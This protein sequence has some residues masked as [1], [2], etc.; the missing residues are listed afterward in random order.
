VNRVLR[1]IFGTE[2]NEVT[3]GW[4]KL[5]NDSSKICILHQ[6]LN[7]K[8]TQDGMG[9]ACSTH[10]GGNKLIQSLDGKTTGRNHLDYPVAD[11]RTSGRLLETQSITF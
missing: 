7:D 5:H 8:T 10:W 1:R 2:R 4:R 11:R 3:E 6:I 9:G